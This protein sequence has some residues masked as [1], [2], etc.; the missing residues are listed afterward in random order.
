MAF[1]ATIFWVV[2]QKLRK[3]SGGLYRRKNAFPT[4][5]SYSSSWGG[6]KSSFCWSAPGRVMRGG[7]HVGG[8]VL[9]QHMLPGSVWFVLCAKFVSSQPQ[10]CE[11]CRWTGLPA[12]HTSPPLQ[13]QIYQHCQTM[14]ITMLSIAHRP[15]QGTCAEGVL[16]P[17]ALSFLFLPLPPP[18]AK[19][20]GVSGPILLF[21]LCFAFWGGFSRFSDTFVTKS[22]WASLL[23]TFLTWKPGFFS[24]S[25]PVEAGS[26][27]HPRGVLSP[28]D[29]RNPIFSGPETDPERGFPEPPSPNRVGV[30]DPPGLDKTLQ[31]ARD[32][33]S[34]FSKFGDWG[35]G[36][37]PPPPGGST[38]SVFLNPHGGFSI[39]HKKPKN[40]YTP[41][42]TLKSGAPRG[43]PCPP[44]GWMFGVH[45]S[46]E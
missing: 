15:S 14:G 43:F 46:P 38:E 7:N 8:G 37:T 29:E 42:L 28:L 44:P 16:T 35:S 1:S 17:I 45:P 33:R 5:F 25:F 34:L 20:G 2:I 31:Q 3:V 4:L 21:F 6:F 36:F 11:W 40:F 12:T 10:L 32:Q 13:A 39:L 23:P 22:P 30:G 41:K 27:C 9:S 18:P 24:F 26:T 19:L